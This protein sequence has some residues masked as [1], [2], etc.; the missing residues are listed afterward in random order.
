MER[1]WRVGTG[2]SSY[3]KR[4]HR[5]AVSQRLRNT[6]LECVFVAFFAQYAKHMRRIVLSPVACPALQYI[7]TLSHKRHDFRVGRDGDG[8]EGELLMCFDFPFKFRLKYFSF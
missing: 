2:P 1:Y 7:Y 6:D 8:G 4:I 5:A 3:E